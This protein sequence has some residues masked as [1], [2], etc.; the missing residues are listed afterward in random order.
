MQTS[1]FFFRYKAQRTPVLVLKISA[2]SP[3]GGR[4]DPYPNKSFNQSFRA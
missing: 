4:L 3:S 2:A 1:L